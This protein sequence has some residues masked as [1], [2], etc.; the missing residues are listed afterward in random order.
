MKILVM[1]IWGAHNENHKLSQ[2]LCFSST[3]KQ[4]N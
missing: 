2:G 4:I 1:M 3:L